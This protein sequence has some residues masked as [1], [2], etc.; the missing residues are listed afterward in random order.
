MIEMDFIERLRS[1]HRPVVVDFWAPWCAP[2]RAI[3]PVVEK[4]EMEYTGRV[5]L[6]RV[7]TDEQPDLLRSLRIYG[8]PTLIAYH[9][10]KEVGRR[11]G[12]ATATVLSS[13]FVSAL[14][15]EMPVQSGPDLHDRFL[16]LGTGLALVGLA[17]LCGLSGSGLLVGGLGCV[18][19]FTAIY[20]RCPIYRMVSLHLK[21]LIQRESTQPKFIGGKYQKS[22]W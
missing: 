13:L 8:I 3:R 21:G 5:D 4:L 18:I 17:I 22:S 16:R 12:V 19:I 15:G 14:T 20:D 1:N 10:G 6:W 11:T 2:C 9:D 7:N